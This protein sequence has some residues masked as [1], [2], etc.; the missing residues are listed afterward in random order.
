MQHTLVEMTAGV[1]GCSLSDSQP[2][3][4]VGPLLRG[5]QAVLH[6]AMEVWHGIGHRWDTDRDRRK[7]TRVSIRKQR[8]L[9]LCTIDSD[10]VKFVQIFGSC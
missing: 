2:D 10:C 8:G 5:P 7:Q 4:G 1:F 3:H 6:R 9:I